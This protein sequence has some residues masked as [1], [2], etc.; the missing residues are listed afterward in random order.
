[1]RSISTNAVIGEISFNIVAAFVQFERDNMM[2]IRHR[3]SYLRGPTEIRAGDIE[4]SEDEEKIW[5]VS[6]QRSF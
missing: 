1:M 3:D 5:F 6:Q 4:A 2:K